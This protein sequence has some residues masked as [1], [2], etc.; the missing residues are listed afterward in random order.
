MPLTPEWGMDPQMEPNDTRTT[1]QRQGR[2]LLTAPVNGVVNTGDPVMVIVPAGQRLEVEASVLNKDVG[3]VEAG[4]IVEVKLEAFPFTRYGTIHGE[5]MH[6]SRDAIE[7]EQQGL[8]YQTKV[9][10][11][12]QQI[13][14]DGRDVNLAAG[15]SATVEIKTGKRPIIEFLL[16]PLFRYRDEGLRER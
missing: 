6:I 4:Q 8:I 12:A 16:A 9:A 14:V 5:L 7:D 3:F 15:M 2:Q 10:L 1:D 13:L 11:N